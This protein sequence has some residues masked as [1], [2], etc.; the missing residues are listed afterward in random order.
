[1]PRLSQSLRHRDASESSLI[2]ACLAWLTLH[3]VLAFRINTGGAYYEKKDQRPQFVRFAFVG[4]PDIHGTLPNGR[5]LYIET[6]RHPRK[7]TW[8]QIQFLARA[9]QNRALVGVIYTVD[10]LIELV[11]PALRAG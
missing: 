10:E 6:K 4:C 11:T 7:P 3:K 5:S 9:E 2:R 8:A 1:M